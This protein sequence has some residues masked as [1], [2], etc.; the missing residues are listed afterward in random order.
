[1]AE[2]GATGIADRARNERLTGVV[3]KERL[4]RIQTLL[5]DHGIPMSKRQIAMDQNG[6]V[7]L[8]LTLN[9]PPKCGVVG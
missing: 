3:D 4:S 5:H 6:D 9:L 7:S 1:M 8:N 2:G